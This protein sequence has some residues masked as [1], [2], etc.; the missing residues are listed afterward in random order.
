M[1]YSISVV[2][3]NYN[4][5]ELL[6]RYLPFTFHALENS[7]CKYEI[8]LVD[9]ASQDDS[10]T[11]I[12]ENHP[13]ITII[14]NAQ[15]KGFSFSCNRG[16]MAA[17]HDLV[18]LLNS[19]IRLAPD[20]LKKLLPYFR[21]SNTFGVMGKILDKSGHHVEVAAK[22]PRFNG[23]KLK[24]DKQAY[25][26]SSQSS[27]IPTTFLSGANCLVDRKKLLELEGFDE[28]Y[29]P[30]YTEDL[31]LSMRAWKLGWASYYEHQATCVHL[32]SH[33][34]KNFFQKEKVKEIYFRNRMLFHAIHMD[35]KDLKRWRLYLLW[36]EVIPKVMLG[37][38]WILRSYA[39]YKAHKY[40]IRSSRRK[41]RNLMLSNKGRISIAEVTE[42]IR[43][44][45]NNKEITV[46]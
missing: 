43:G 18:L 36:G 14:Q 24:S 35:R 21:D 29:S 42:T 1:N 10:V 7:R 25:P 23:Y 34:T 41:I 2:L 20:Y 6:E 26:K 11:F 19:D 33:T 3:P 40:Q 37:Q 4:G 15:N 22:I 12:Q 30:F 38:L 13:T 27:K 31:D 17:K 45:L 16:I 32:G 39:A 9:D 46:L 44:L 28:I 5:K 8:I